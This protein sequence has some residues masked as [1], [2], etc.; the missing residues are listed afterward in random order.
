[1]GKKKSSSATATVKKSRKKVD[2][3]QQ[4]I[5]G[6]EPVRV[7]EIDDQA[8]HYREARDSRMES[9][10]EEVAQK[11]ILLELMQ[12][13]GLDYYPIPDTDYEV[14]VVSGETDVKV[15]KR[16]KEKENQE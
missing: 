10:E 2:P 1:M 12:K 15:R 16:K 5:E 3:K 13:H 11:G 14:I 8:E 4:Y 9:T 7:A 6:T